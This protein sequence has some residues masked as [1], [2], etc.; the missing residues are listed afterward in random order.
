MKF[1][2]KLLLSA[3]MLVT[4]TACATG[5]SPTT[6]ASPVPA[7]PSL[8]GVFEGITPCSS[9]TRPLPQ[10]PADSNCEQ[11]IWK[12]IL[13]Q[14]PVTSAPTTYT[15]HS[16]YGVPQQGTNGLAG[17]GTSITMEGSWAVLTG[18]KL[19]PDAV[20]Y[21]LNP[22]AS[23]TAVSFLKLNEDILHVLSS[24]KTL[25]VG[26]AGWSYT[27]N[28][29][30]N[31]IPGPVTAQQDPA[32]GSTRP[33]LPP[34]PAG[35]SVLGVF[36]GRTP[37]HEIVFEFANMAP[38]P[39]CLKIK[40]KLTLYQDQ[41]TGAPSTYLYQGT[42]TLR[43]GA[44]AIL[45]GTDSDPEAVV[46]QLQLDDAKPP[47]SFLKADENH[48]FLLDRELNLLVGTTLFSYTLSRTDHGN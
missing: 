40:W 34:M 33:P 12:I 7:G 28:R 17:G 15:L 24:E 30:D 6:T 48:L 32:E 2:F 8:H 23:Q 45:S 1:F 27:L 37:C 21:Q 36:E 39:G 11:M 47:I 4:V 22:D 5:I 19:D 18:T 35:S 13:Y 44:W 25:L 31:R 20:V 29:T 43:E 16:A 26:N 41:T 10:I 14:D 42:R 46:Y 3:G 38:Y 9:L